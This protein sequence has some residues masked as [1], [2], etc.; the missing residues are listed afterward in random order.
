MYA[1]VANG[2]QCICKTQ[3]K[4]EYIL[5]IY[6]YPKFIRCHTEEEGRD[7]IRRNQR[8]YHDRSI[9]NYGTTAIS[10]YV[11]VDYIISNNTIFYNLYLSKIGVLKLRKSEDIDINYGSDF[12]KVKITNV[13][14]DNKLISHHV[15]AIRR[16]LKLIGNYVDV[17]VVVPDI[18]VYIAV[19]SYKGNNYILRGIQKD[20]QSR[21]GGVSFSILEKGQD[22]LHGR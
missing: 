6:P 8:G 14:L 19:T 16:I 13:V 9:G 18:S 4:L 12:I 15:I 17:N 11:T 2:I 21:L 22:K 10:G 5:A 7:W 3:K 20:I 1:V